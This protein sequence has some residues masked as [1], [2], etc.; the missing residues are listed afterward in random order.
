MNVGYAKFKKSLIVEQFQGN[1]LN[2]GS[3]PSWRD[4]QASA[5]VFLYLVFYSG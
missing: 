3:L 4:Q 5:V 1:Y 2:S